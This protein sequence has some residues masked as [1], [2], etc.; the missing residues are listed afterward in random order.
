MKIVQGKRQVGQLAKVTGKNHKVGKVVQRREDRREAR[1]LAAKGS[2]G[3][4]YPV[5]QY[6]AADLSRARLEALAVGFVVGVGTVAAVL[7]F[8]GVV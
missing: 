5:G 3:R 1:R 8:L 2:I 7:A 6:T 4:P